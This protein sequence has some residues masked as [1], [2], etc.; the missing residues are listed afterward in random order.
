MLFRSMKSTG[1]NLN[2][3]IVARRAGDVEQ[4]WANPDKANKELGWSADTP[5]GDVLKSA[6]KWQQTL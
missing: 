5:I 1:V 6:G 2:Y 3:E 4:V